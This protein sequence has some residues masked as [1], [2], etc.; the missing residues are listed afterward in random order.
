MDLLLDKYP[1]PKVL[2]IGA[3]VRRFILNCKRQPA[4]RE[5]GPIT[6]MADEKPRPIPIPTKPQPT[7][8][9]KCFSSSISLDPSHILPTNVFIKFG[10]LHKQFDTVFNPEIEGYNGASGPFKAKVNMGP[11]EPPQRKGRLPQYPRERLVELQQK[12][13]KLEELGVFKQPE[14]VGI[15]V[16]YLNLPS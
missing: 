2:R 9:E 5:K 1:L 10:N 11:V 15:A 3:W 4:E 6:R 7:P 14:D 13:D 12:F 8:K 16:G